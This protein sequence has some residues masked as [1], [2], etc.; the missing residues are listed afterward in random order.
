MARGTFVLDRA[1][2]Y[3]LNMSVSD[4]FTK[5]DARQ[6][7]SYCRHLLYHETHECHDRA[8]QQWVTRWLRVYVD[9]LCSEELAVLANSL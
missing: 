7:Y 8:N 1:A 4:S 3:I 2:A 6:R 9:T 5:T